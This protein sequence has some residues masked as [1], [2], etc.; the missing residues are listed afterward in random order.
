[1]KVARG[2]F[3]AGAAAGSVGPAIARAAD[4]LRVG[5]VPG[6]GAAS[7]YYADQLGLFKNAGI[8][9]NL[10]ILASGPA[11]AAATMGGTLDVG[12]VNTGSLATMRLNGAPIRAIAPS[13]VVG[14]GPIGDC[15]MV[16][17]NAPIRTGR[18]FTGKTVATNAL[19]TMQ[20]AGGMDWIDAHGGDAK[21]VKYLELPVPAMKEAVLAGRIDAGILSEPFGTMA[22]PALRTLGPLYGGIRKPFLIFALCATEPWL[23]NNAV[24]AAKFAAA[25]RDAGAWANKPENQA[26]RRQMNVALTKLDPAVI[27]KMIPWEMG[28]SLGAPMLAPVLS[29][30][31][32]YGFLEHEVH[33]DDLVWRAF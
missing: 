1:M 9:V 31:L 22:L 14:N 27:D 23:R 21:S 28:T 3:L 20:H 33:P 11:L 18:D 25:V 2:I 12:G 8:D 13:A 6:D 15:L 26:A 5:I 19:G 24:T 4:A 10:T 29:T 17:P 30:M 7:A 32:H 16:A